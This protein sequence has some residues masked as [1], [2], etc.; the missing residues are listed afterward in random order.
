MNLRW[1]WLTNPRV[2]GSI[3]TGPTGKAQV[4]RLRAGDRASRAPFTSPSK[5][6]D[7]PHAPPRPSYV[8]Q[9]RGRILLQ[10]GQDGAVT[11]EV[12]YVP[13]GDNTFLR[14]ALWIK[15]KQRCYWCRKP[16]ELSEVEIDHIIPQKKK[17][18]VAEREAIYKSYDLPADYD[19]HALANLAPICGPCN[20]EKSDDVKAGVGVILSKLN[21]ARALRLSVEKEVASIKAAPKAS[22]LLLQCSELSL[23]DTKVLDAA[24]VFGPVIMRKF[25]EVGIE[26][27]REERFEFLGSYS[28]QD[29]TVT[30]SLSIG[31]QAGVAALGR[32]RWE[33]VVKRATFGILD[34]LGATVSARVSRKWSDRGRG[35]VDAGD[36]APFLM[37]VEIDQI[38]R[39]SIEDDL[40]DIELGGEFDGSL[41][42]EAQ[43]SSADGSGLESESYHQA[44]SGRFVA[45]VTYDLNAFEDGLDLVDVSINL[46]ESVEA[47]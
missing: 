44:M 35:E 29:L 18:K 3:P 38:I 6:L 36:P 7:V 9:A 20:G 11:V 45:V 24:K 4:S 37:S 17:L 41:F 19:V 22:K 10:G 12:R 30:T 15:W 32:Q 27:V 34:S 5:S 13:G 21:R 42:G 14:L 25:D 43:L 39:F 47:D 8:R 16:K 40:A 1:P 26:F 46:E 31:S 2:V 33:S 28:P 23:Y